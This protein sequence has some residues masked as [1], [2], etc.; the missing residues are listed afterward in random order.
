MPT[1]WSNTGDSQLGET[2]ISIRI[3]TDHLG[4]TFEGGEQNSEAIKDLDAIDELYNALQGFATVDMN[5][6]NRITDTVV[7]Y[8]LRYVSYQTDFKTIFYQPVIEIQRVA[9]KPTTNIKTNT[10]E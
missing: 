1:Q 7:E 4:D 9:A 5:P 8:G 2:I 10:D 3:Y 6:L